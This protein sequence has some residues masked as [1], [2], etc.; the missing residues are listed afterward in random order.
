MSTNEDIYA[1]ANTTEAD[2]VRIVNGIC[3]QLAR[4]YTFG[5]YTYKDICQE[6]FVEALKAL[7]K[8]TGVCYDPSRPLDDFLFIHID[9]RLRNL[10]RNKF[11]KQKIPCKTCPLFDRKGERAKSQCL[12]YEN[13]LDCNLY[14]DW[15]FYNNRKMQLNSAGGKPPRT[16]DEPAM[17]EQDRG[18]LLALI[19]NK[20]SANL[21]ADFLKILGGV[22]V[23]RKRKVEVQD[24]VK[25][26]IIDSGEYPELDSFWEALD[27]L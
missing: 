15:H 27:E 23:P 16:T 4:N 25:A 12:K 18:E 13:R 20:L 7:H 10:R 5:S 22:T 8:K 17:R 9:N 11:N 14:S 1:R 2:L 24:A 19:D 6:A 26:I 21:R 3:L